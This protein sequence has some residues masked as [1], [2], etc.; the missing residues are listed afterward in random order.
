MD[1]MD[2]VCLDD[3]LK[4]LTE[5]DQDPLI[6]DPDIDQKKLVRIYGQ[7]ANYVLQLSRLKFRRIGTIS[8][9]S[10]HGPSQD[11]P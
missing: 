8:N 7:I 5:S 3:L 6:L 1:F 9:T 11:D 4:K 10:D 2:G